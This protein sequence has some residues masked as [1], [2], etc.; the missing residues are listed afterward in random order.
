MNQT[1]VWTQASKIFADVSELSPKKALAHLYGIQSITEEVRNAVI[2]LI[3]S[4]SQASQYFADEISPNYNVEINNNQNFKPGQMLDEYKLLEELGHGGM[5]QVFKAERINT[6]Q[7]TLVAIKIF[8]PRDN[9]QE[10]LNHFINEQKILSELSHPHIVKMLHGGKTNDEIAYLV[11]ELIE[12]ALPLDRY[13]HKNKSSIKNQM[14]LIAQCAEALTYSHANLIIHRDLK[15]DNILINQNNELKIVDF[16]IA[17]LINNSISGNNTTIMALTPNYAAPEQINSEPISVK[18]DIFSLAVVAL[19]LMVDKTP[20]PKDRLIKSCA[21]DEAYLDDIFKSLKCDKDIKNIL[22][23]ALQQ[24]PDKRYSSMQSFADDLNNYLA[25]EPVNATSQSFFY[26]IQKFSKRRAALFATLVSFMVF[27]VVGSFLGYQ[28]YKQITIEAEKANQVKQFMLDAYAQTNPDYAKGNVITAED[29]LNSTAKKLEG[30]QIDQEIKF[31]LLQTIGIAYGQIGQPQKA[32]D[33]LKKSLK[34]NVLDS[35]SLAYQV[36][37]LNKAENWQEL[38]KILNHLKIDAIKSNTDK[39]KLYRV[40]AK[41]QA[42]ESNFDQ[43]INTLNKAIA[44]NIKNQDRNEEFLSQKLLAEFLFLQSKPEEGITLL[45]NLLKDPSLDQTSSLGMGLRADLSMLYTDIGELDK[46]HVSWTELIQHQRQIL[47]DNHPELAKSL[48]QKAGVLRYQGDLKQ[49]MIKINEAHT[50]NLKVFGDN[51]ITTAS[52]YNS[53]AVILYQTGDYPK[54]IEYMYKAIKIFEENQSDDYADTLELKTNLAALLLA[55]KRY[56]EAETIAR[57]VYNIQLKKLGETHDSTIYS[58]QTLA[59]ALSSLGN[60]VEAQKLAE[61]A[62]ENSIKHLGDKN[63]LTLGAYFSIAQIYFKQ[64]KYNQTLE[65]YQVILNKELIAENNPN[66]PRLMQSL[67]EVYTKIN[68]KENAQKYHLKT[69]K[70]YENVFGKEHKKTVE[71]HNKYN[72]FLTT[73]K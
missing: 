5:S 13:C 26:R 71:A 42:K 15:P 34:I 6:D 23:K 28:Q 46:A 11:M 52:S 44:L 63:P 67:A 51:N 39:A 54:A 2:T 55:S 33:F 19:D 65:Q 57:E 60:L 9:S 21:N 36:Q 14:K 66:H 40:L 62:L 10:L 38:S 17:K 29:I 69:L 4:G 16:G 53:L 18:T 30:S 73:K 32:A 7:Q 58:Q 3:N 27:L 24:E 64:N 48:L 1:Q 37:F 70:S 43:A 25:N 8:A 59:K 31:E 45:E 50:I 20:L 12:E 35:K 56:Q 72:A 41:T 68:D 49:A 47:G 61:N 22:R